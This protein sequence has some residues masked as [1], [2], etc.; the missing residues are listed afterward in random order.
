MF[1]DFLHGLSEQVTEE[2][3]LV[4]VVGGILVEEEEVVVWTGQFPKRQFRMQSN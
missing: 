1:S 3:V 4:D 2:G